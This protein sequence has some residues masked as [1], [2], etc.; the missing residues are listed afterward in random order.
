MMI[1]SLWL[2]LESLCCWCA[3]SLIQKGWAVETA[4]PMETVEK[5]KIFPPFPQGL[6]KLSA[7]CASSFPQF[8]QP[9][10]LVIYKKGNPLRVFMPP[11]VLVDPPFP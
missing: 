7:L 5:S 1:S 11:L 3:R 8:P 10:R 4:A 9:R 6:G 2:F